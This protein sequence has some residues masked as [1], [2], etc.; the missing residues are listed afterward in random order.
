[1]P[2]DDA[3]CLKRFPNAKYANG[4]TSEGLDYFADCDIVL[5][6]ETFYNDH[7]VERLKKARPNIQ[8]VLQPNYEQRDG[9]GATAYAVPTVW[10]YP[11]WKEPKAYLPL[12]IDR[13]RLKFKLR[14]RAKTFV[15]N[16]GMQTADDRN[17]TLKVLRAMEFVKSDIELIVRFQQFPEK[18][19]NEFSGLLKS[20]TRIQYDDTK[21]PDY[22]SIW[23]Q[24][25]VFVYPRAYAGLSLPVNE[26]M[27]CGLPVL[28]TDM[29][30]QNE[31][32]PKELLIPVTRK[33][34]LKM[35]RVIEACEVDPRVIAEKIDALAGMDI[36][37]LS[38]QMNHVA[39]AWSWE[40]MLP[41]YN[42][43]FNKICLQQ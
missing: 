32:L 8:F 2:N 40:T 25:D 36:T 30:P 29:N 35:F 18:L 22:W 42:N 37:K 23:E 11:Y 7:A 10:N 20:D 41:K 34:P 26:A 17:G 19:Y 12:P 43:F 13:E 27:S 16:G 21:Y 33:Y 15:H 1:L 14:T 28:M 6:F 38:N 31:Y 24:G 39:S 4:I 9:F 5:S 3:E